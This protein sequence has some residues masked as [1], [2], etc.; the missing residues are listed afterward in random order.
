MKSLLHKYIWCYLL[1]FSTFGTY[2]CCQT[3]FNFHCRSTMILFSVWIIF[4]HAVKHFSVL[5]CS[6][7]S[8]RSQTEQKNKKNLIW[9]TCIQ[10]F[11]NK[12]Q[13]S[14]AYPW[15]S[16]YLCLR[17][18]GATVL[19]LMILIKTVLIHLGSMLYCKC[20]NLEK[21]CI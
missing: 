4:V 2:T 10:R 11:W 7:C 3:S 21:Q 12:L 20:L 19:I 17:F 14:S 15:Y 8:V 1:G 5:S 9:D 13:I 16:K 6:A 18:Y